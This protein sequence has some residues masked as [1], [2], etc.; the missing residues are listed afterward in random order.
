MTSQRSYIHLHSNTTTSTSKIHHINH[1]NLHI[2]RIEHIY[3]L[4]YPIQFNSIQSHPIPPY[5][6]HNQAISSQSKSAHLQDSSP[7]YLTPPSHFK[8]QYSI[9]TKLPRS[10]L[11]ILSLDYPHLFLSIMSQMTERHQI[12]GLT[13]CEQT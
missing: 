11:C 2:S 7:I 5:H 13:A 9:L 12:W 4:P 1:R 8:N 10:L 3:T 6:T